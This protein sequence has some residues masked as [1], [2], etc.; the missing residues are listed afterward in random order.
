M[1]P[2]YPD[3]FDIYTISL[4]VRKKTVSLFTLKFGDTCMERVSYEYPTKNTQ[5]K[6]PIW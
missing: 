3:F 1:N 6:N 5:D 2:L 4:K